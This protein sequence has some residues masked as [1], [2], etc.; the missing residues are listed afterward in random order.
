LALIKEILFTESKE[1]KWLILLS[2]KA[3]R[4]EDTEDR[5][6]HEGVRV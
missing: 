3:F 5:K 4:H 1:K 6:M 2:Q